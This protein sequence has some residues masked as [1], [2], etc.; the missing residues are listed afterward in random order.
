[1]KKLTI[2]DADEIEITVLSENSNSTII[3]KGE[4][5]ISA[6]SLFFLTKKEMEEDSKEMLKDWTKKVTSDG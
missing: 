6:H 3:T 2:Y 1:M 4:D 5:L